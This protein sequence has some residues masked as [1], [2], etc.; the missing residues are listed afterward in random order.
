[1]TDYDDDVDLGEDDDSE[2]EDEDEL[3]ELEPLDDEL[4]F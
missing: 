4:A 3:H 2:L 1:M